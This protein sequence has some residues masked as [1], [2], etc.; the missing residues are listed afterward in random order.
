MLI[1]HNWI[2]WAAFL[3]LPIWPKIDFPYW[4][5]GWGT[6]CSF[7]F[8]NSYI[9]TKY[10]SSSN[11]TFGHITKITS[12]SGQVQFDKEYYIMMQGKWHNSML[13]LGWNHSNIVLRPLCFLTP[14]KSVLGLWPVCG[15]NHPKKIM[16]IFCSRRLQD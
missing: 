15:K 14:S 3:E 8:V 12:L 16:H 4:K 2:F 6:L 7:Y 13:P 10:W 1:I 9:V 5:L 11:C